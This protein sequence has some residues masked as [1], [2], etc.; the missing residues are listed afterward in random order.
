VGTLDGY[1]LA[2]QLLGAARNPNMQTNHD[3]GA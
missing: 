2:M 3:F 1:R